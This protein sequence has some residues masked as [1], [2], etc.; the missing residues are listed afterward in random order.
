MHA[1]F[2]QKGYLVLDLFGVCRHLIR[3]LQPGTSNQ[4]KW[5]RIRRPLWSPSTLQWFLCKIYQ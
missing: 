3:V 1:L 5:I 4:D 2:V